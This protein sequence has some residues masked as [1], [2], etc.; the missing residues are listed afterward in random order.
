MNTPTVPRPQPEL[1]LTLSPEARRRLLALLS[2]WV[3]R[4]WTTQRPQS[5]GNHE[6]I[7]R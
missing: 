3:L 2:R 7:S 4:H 5:G 6:R 1:W